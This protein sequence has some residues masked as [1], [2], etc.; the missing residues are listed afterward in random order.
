MVGKKIRK[1]TFIVSILALT[2][3]I[4]IIFN[5]V[6]NSRADVEIDAN[7]DDGYSRIP[8]IEGFDMFYSSN[9]TYHFLYI[10]APYN[11]SG[12]SIRIYNDEISQN[13]S[14]SEVITSFLHSIHINNKLELKIKKEVIGNIFII[15]FDNTDKFIIVLDPDEAYSPRPSYPIGSS[16]EDDDDGKSKTSIT[17]ADGW[18]SFLESLTLVH[19]IGIGILIALIP[20]LFLFCVWRLKIYPIMVFQEEEKYRSS[21]VGRFISEERSKVL[22]DYWILRFKSGWN[23]VVEYHCTENLAEIRERIYRKVYII[24]EEYPNYILRTLSLPEHREYFKEEIK[25]DYKYYLLRIICR[26]IPNNA[27]TVAL[28][29]S[30]NRMK[31]ETKVKEVDLLQFDLTMKRLTLICDISYKKTVADEKE[32]EKITLVTDRKKPYWYYEDL[33]KDQTVDQKTLKIIEKSIEIIR[34]RDVKKAI[35]LRNSEQNLRSLH[36]L[37]L[38]ERNK[39][40]KE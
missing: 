12:K 5:G 29:S 31:T 3:A 21:K 1:R 22:P 16:S 17:I 25:K 23:G 39:S 28:Y 10:E 6:S 4:L 11:L 20:S 18:K 24:E 27:L 19:G 9:E 14:N 36:G 8:Q 13:I 15:E 37:E 34:I 33:K 26:I 40:Y 2:I 7:K 35:E 30:L 32:G 38:R